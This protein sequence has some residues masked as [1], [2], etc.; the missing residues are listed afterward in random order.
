M[1]TK[2]CLVFGLAV[3]LFLSL[4][5]SHRGAE[6]APPIKIGYL[7]PLTGPFARIGADLRDGWVLHFDE[8]GNKVGGRD[9]QLIV[10]DT[11][12]KPEVGLVKTR[13][14][15]EKDKVDMLAGI[16]STGVAYALRDYVHNQK[17]PLMITNAGADDLT[18]QKRSPYLFRSSLSSSQ[19]G[20]VFGDWIYGKLGKR[21]MVILG[22]DYPG[23]WEWCGSVAYAFVLAGGKV[24]Q[25]LYSPM[26]TTDFA[27]FLTALNRDADVVFSF[28]IGHETIRL[29]TQYQEFGLYGKIQRTTGLGEIDEMIYPQ[30]GDYIVGTIATGIRGNPDSPHFQAFY[31]AFK[32]KFGKE[33]GEFG[34]S[35]Y[36]GAMFVS[37]ALQEVK[38]NIEDKELF[39]KALRGIKITES[40]WGPISF[41]EY[42]HIIRDVPIC[43]LV[44]VGNTF[45][46]DIIDKVPQVSQF[47]RYTPEEFFKKV[48]VWAQ[49]KGKWPEYKPVK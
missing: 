18:K 1:F 43:K 32:G 37:R 24:I 17:I 27:P 44:K 12:G 46:I 42:Q 23:S 2:R 40:G 48:P 20:L 26:G 35:S 38:G 49:M 7:T 41:D 10:E 9:I 21:K 19:L 11:E 8:L 45:R 6:A 39:L 34:N 16:F 15:V 30:I 4:V 13:K 33:P 36:M 5:A 22:Q 31:K 3:V 47:W 14:L 28:H 25:E 29:S